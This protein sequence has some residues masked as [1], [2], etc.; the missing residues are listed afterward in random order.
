MIAN[1]SQKNYNS[2]SNSDSNLLE[3]SVSINLTVL[4][5]AVWFHWN[6]KGWRQSK[7]TQFPQIK[8]PTNHCANSPSL[9]GF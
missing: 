4:S 7:Y 3:V 8:H 9:N 5:F 2:F 6:I 1:I